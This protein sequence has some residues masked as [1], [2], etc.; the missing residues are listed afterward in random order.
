[1]KHSE[2]FLKVRMLEVKVNFWVTEIE[3]KVLIFLHRIH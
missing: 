1:M 2:N 3:V